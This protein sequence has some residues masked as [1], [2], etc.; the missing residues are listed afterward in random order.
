MKQRIDV[1]WLIANSLVSE[2]LAN[3]FNI[4]VTDEYGED[5]IAVSRDK[6]KILE[7]MDGGGNDRLYVTRSMYA[8]DRI[9]GWVA[10]VYGNGVDLI[11]DYTVNLKPYIS[12]TDTICDKLIRADSNVHGGMIEADDLAAVLPDYIAP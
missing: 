12:K 2:L 11:S 7:A 4:T 10:L 6:A 5:A 9:E 3:G 8:T 1:E